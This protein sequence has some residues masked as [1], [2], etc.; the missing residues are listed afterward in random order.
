MPLR[1][2]SGWNIYPDTFI[3]FVE[4][5]YEVI[6]FLVLF[7]SIAFKRPIELDRVLHFFPYQRGQQRE[8]N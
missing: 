2:G 4:I 8:L 6:I 3:V 1:I 5:L 7:I